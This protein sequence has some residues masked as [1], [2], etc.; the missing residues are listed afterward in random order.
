MKRLLY[1]IFSYPYKIFILY[2]RNF[3]KQVFIFYKIK[4]GNIRDRLDLTKKNGV[5][6]YYRYNTSDEDQLKAFSIKDFLVNEKIFFHDDLIIDVGA[7]IG[8]F[9][10]P[11]SSKVKN[12]KI[13]AIEPC[14]ETYDILEKNIKLN[15]VK[16][17]IPC[18]LALSSSNKTTRLY[19]GSTNLGHSLTFENEGACENVETADLKTFF[20]RYGIK[21]CDFMKLNCEGSEF[22]IILSADRETLRKTDFYV[23][24]YHEYYNKKYKKE[25]LIEH[26]KSNG[27]SVTL[28]EKTALIIAKKR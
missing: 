17:V 1:R 6:Y 25:D 24:S 11:L 15:K 28:K 26:L 10:I 8:T 4:T 23:I 14:K 7:H 19:H 18:K 16:N 13:Y 12:G 3:V 20:K 22:E 21:S 9:A 5:K 2:P 27:F